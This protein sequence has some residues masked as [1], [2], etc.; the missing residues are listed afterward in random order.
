MIYIFSDHS[1]PQVIEIMESKT[2]DMNTI[3]TEYS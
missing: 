1:W 2:K 3:D